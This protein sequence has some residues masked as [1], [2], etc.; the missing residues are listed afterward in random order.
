MANVKEI[1]QHLDDLDN[2]IDTGH[3]QKESVGDY[4]FYQGDIT[5]KEFVSKSREYIRQLSMIHKGIAAKSHNDVT[6]ALPLHGVIHWAFFPEQTPNFGDEIL[7]VYPPEQITKPIVTIYDRNTE[8]IDGCK[9]AVI[10]PC[11]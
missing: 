6:A 2:L 11:V 4:T 9:Y 5:L 3:F 10:T 8:W 7:L 1:E